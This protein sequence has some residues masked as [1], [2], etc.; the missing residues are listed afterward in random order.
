[1]SVFVTGDTHLTI[2]L[3][4]VIDYDWSGLTKND[5][6]IILGDVGLTWDKS[7]LTKFVIDSFNKMPF[8][9]LCVLGNHE[10]YNILNEY[11]TSEFLGGKVKKLADSV[12]YLMNGEIFII[13]D[14]TFFVMGGARSTD[15]ECRVEGVSWWAEEI[16]SLA[17]LNKG[18]KNL[19][20]HDGKVDYV[21]TH[22]APTEIAYKT[23]DLY[24]EGR[25]FEPDCLTDFLQEEIADKITVANSWHYGHY[26]HDCTFGDKNEYQCHYNQI[27]KLF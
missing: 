12:Y 7:E 22:C 5:Y 25:W 10:N 4:K 8:T 24:S 9:T 17:Q 3:K 16:P 27:V 11:E 19:M 1:M 13:D 26:H 14:K 2:D 21:L 18:I 15:K 23:M 20:F 6:L